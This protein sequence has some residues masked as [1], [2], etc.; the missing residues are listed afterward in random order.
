MMDGSRIARNNSI[1][2]TSLEPLSTASVDGNG[3]RCE[4]IQTSYDRCVQ[5]MGVIGMQ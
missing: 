3:L 2:G 1:A 5:I 4:H